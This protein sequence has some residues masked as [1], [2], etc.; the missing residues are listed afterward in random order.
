MTYGYL[1]EWGAGG[2]EEEGARSMRQECKCCQALKS[3]A[4]DFRAC[5]VL[6]SSLGKPF[7]GRGGGRGEVFLISD[8][9]A[10]ASLGHCCVAFLIGRDS[11]N[12]IRI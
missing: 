11:A 12:K 2:R 9:W 4:R 7:F 3:L 8:A 1:L 5:N 6:C 10:L